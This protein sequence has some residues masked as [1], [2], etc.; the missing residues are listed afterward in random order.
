MFVLSIGAKAADG[1]TGIWKF[2][3]PNMIRI[4]DSSGN[5]WHAVPSTAKYAAGAFGAAMLFDKPG[6]GFDLPKAV[7]ALDTGDFSISFWVCPFEYDTV[8]KYKMKRMLGVSEY[9]KR[10]WNVDMNADGIIEMEMGITPD[11]AEKPVNGG[12]SSAGK[13]ALKTWTHIVITVDRTNAKTRFY[14]NGELNAERPIPAAF[15][16]GSLSLPLPL[17]VGYTGDSSFIGLLD[18]LIISKRIFSA[19]EIRSAYDGEQKNRQ[20]AEYTVPPMK[21][22]VIVEE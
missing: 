2:D 19:D 14:F 12:S 22:I 8:S 17:R 1:I 9:P 4:E 6:A 3:V 21:R 5:G 11:G 7:T 10:W 16:V 13:V 15:A 18:E 20:S